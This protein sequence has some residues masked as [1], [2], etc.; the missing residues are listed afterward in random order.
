MQRGVVK[1]GLG[2]SDMRWHSVVNG[3]GRT[4]ITGRF[5]KLTQFR[6]AEPLHQFRIGD[7]FV[8]R[9]GLLLDGA[10]GRNQKQVVRR[11]SSYLERE[12]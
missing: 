6:L 1:P 5:P 3:L 7:E 4:E 2:T 11:G 8:A 10:I 12:L 9:R